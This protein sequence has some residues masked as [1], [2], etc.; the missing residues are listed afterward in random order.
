MSNTKDLTQGSIF[1]S[2][3]LF[4]LPIAL[5]LLL[6]QLYNTVDV[7]SVGR[8]VGKE[9]LAAVGSTSYI[10]NI[11]VGL[12]AGL[13]S[14]ASAISAQSFGAHDTDKLADSVKSSLVLSVLIGIVATFMGLIIVKP[15]LRI[16]KTPAEV[17]SDAAIYLRIYFC[18]L[19][20]V[21]VYSFVSGIL[22]AM[23]DS[24]LP[25]ILLAVSSVLNIVLDLVFV[26]SFK[27]GI[28]GVGVATIIAQYF[29]AILAL[30]LLLSDCRKM[31]RNSNSS[32]K[33]DICKSIFRIGFPSGLQQCV[34]SFSNAIVQSY[35]N[36]FGAACMAGWAAYSKLD[37]YIM[38]PISSMALAV[39]T[40]VGQ[41]YGA[42]KYERM[43]KGILTC[44]LFGASVAFLM[45]FIITAFSG[46]LVLLFSTDPSVYDYALYFV[47]IL[48]PLY[49][50][51]S[52]YMIL[53]A[54]M[55]GVGKSF[56]PSTIT[57]IALVFLRQAELLVNKYCLGNSLFIVVLTFPIGW[58]LCDTAMFIY[59]R[60]T[61]K[62]VLE[63]LC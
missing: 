45:G 35:V 43:K 52:F 48:T 6:Q 15:M 51:M 22:R 36:F 46:K 40:F 47:R 2:V 12:C 61:M 14:G 44:I 50:F 20:G 7:I 62:K 10:I 49:G 4:S 16:M 5:E 3:L 26:I 19:L 58:I 56:W 18:G 63:N 1:K 17:F 29:S 60:K 38:I 11:F 31:F 57:I 34:T 23:G 39:T 37:V 28:V 55:R 9:A 33:T 53:A 41:N 27:W 32:F 54:A 21:F 42:K 24:V 30:I 59:Y 25:L 8:F 13:A